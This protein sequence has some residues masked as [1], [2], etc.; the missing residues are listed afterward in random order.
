[1]EEG[2]VVE[3]GAAEEVLV[4]PRMESTKKFLRILE[5]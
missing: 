1:M 2:V 4:T 5:R 3:A